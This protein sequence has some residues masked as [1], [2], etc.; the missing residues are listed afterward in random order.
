MTNN[1]RMDGAKLGRVQGKLIDYS[2]DRANVNHRAPYDTLHLVDA[3]LSN[4]VYVF[5]AYVLECCQFS[6]A[7]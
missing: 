1:Y 4:C 6:F 2:E 5:R 7:T 3:S